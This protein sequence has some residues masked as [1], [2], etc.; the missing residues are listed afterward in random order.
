MKTTIETTVKT[1]GKLSFQ[2]EVKVKPI[3][4]YYDESKS[5]VKSNCPI[6]E[7]A[8]LHIDLSSSTPHNCPTCGINLDWRDKE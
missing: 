4:H 1:L 3:H 8:G 5:Y 2:K 7:S 6:C